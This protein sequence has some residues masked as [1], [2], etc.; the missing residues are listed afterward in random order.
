MKIQILEFNRVEEL[1]TK[2]VSFAN[3]DIRETPHGYQ[4][5]VSGSNRL[6]YVPRTAVEFISY[7]VVRDG[8]VF[9]QTVEVK[10]DE[11]K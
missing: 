2:L 8:E 11:K 7:G 3:S 5:L 10:K 9:P 6:Y 4:I 1:R